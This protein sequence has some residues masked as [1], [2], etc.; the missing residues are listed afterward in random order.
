VEYA[1]LI[2]LISVACIM[3]LTAFSDSNGDMMTN[4]ADKIVTAGH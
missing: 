3:A 1:L 4:S 2:A